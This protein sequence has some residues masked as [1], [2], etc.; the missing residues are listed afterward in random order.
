[1]GV[2]KAFIEIDG[3]PLWRRQFE[4][5][6]SVGPQELFIAGPAHEE[7]SNAGGTVIPDAQSNAGPLAALVAALRRCSTT[8]VLA[9]AVDLPHMTAD[10]LG[11]L[12]DNRDDGLGVIPVRNERFEP[13]AAVYPREALPLAESCL[14]SGDH[15]LQAFAARCV[16]ARFATTI[17]IST[18]DEP[19]FLNMNTPADLAAVA[20]E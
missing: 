12:L 20:A 10:H 18:A 8:H 15:S 13:V 4:I 3:V 16:A 7:W 14:A 9:L 17:E 11:H 19:L 6:R 1:M 5:L 2:D